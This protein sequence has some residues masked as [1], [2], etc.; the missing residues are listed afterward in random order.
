MLSSLSVPGPVRQSRS[1]L[2]NKMG[3]VST[4]WFTQATSKPRVLS[5]FAAA[6]HATAKRT[7]KPS[8][9][10]SEFVPT[11]SITWKFQPTVSLYLHVPTCPMYLPSNENI[12]E[13]KSR[14]IKPRT[15]WNL[16]L[17]HVSYWARSGPTIQP[18]NS[19]AA[20]QPLRP[21]DQ[22][23]QWCHPGLTWLHPGSMNQVVWVT[24][25]SMSL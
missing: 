4:L 2:S 10:P 8:W 6:W 15:L 14:Q 17:I 7:S 12:P 18:P 16:Y 9:S 19:H 24:V 3:P 20:F 22:Q 25:F 1:K 11:F 21:I 13:G 23:H 5:A